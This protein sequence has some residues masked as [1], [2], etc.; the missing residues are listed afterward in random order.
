MEN[1]Q[2]PYSQSWT[3]HRVRILSHGQHTESVFLVMENAFVKVSSIGADFNIDCRRMFKFNIVL[4]SIIFHFLT[5]NTISGAQ[6]V[7]L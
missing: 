2:S 6:A 3:T 1:T 5:E 4:G 7:Y